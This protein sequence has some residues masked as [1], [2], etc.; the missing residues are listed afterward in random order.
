MVGESVFSLGCQINFGKVLVYFCSMKWTTL[1]FLIGILPLL[2]V[3]AQ[4]IRDY[5]GGYT[6]N[7][8]R[9]TGKFSYYLTPENE[10]V[11]QGPFRFELKLLDSLG[12]ERLTKLHVEGVYEKY[13]KDKSWSYQLEDHVVR[14][15]DVENRDV[16]AQIETKRIDLLAQYAKGKLHGTWSYSEKNWMNEQFLETFRTNELIFSNDRLTGKVRFENLNP[17]N[18]FLIAGTLTSEGLMDGAWDF[19]YQES[20]IPIREIRRYEKG[21]LIGLQ[22]NNEV[23]GE[24]LDEVVFFNAIQK[25][26]S[27]D[28]GFEVDYTLSDRFFGLTFNDGFGQQ[29]KEFRQQYQ[30]TQ[31]LEDALVRLLRFEDE[32][33]VKADRLLKSP[34]QTRRFRYDLSKNEEEAYQAAVVRYQELKSAVDLVLSSSFLELNRQS[35]DS[36]TLAGAYFERLNQKLQD[37]IPVVEVIK[38]G[39]I[40]YFDPLFYQKNDLDFLPASDTLFLDAKSVGDARV[41]TFPDLKIAKSFGT[42]LLKYLEKELENFRI[43]DRFLTDQQQKFRQNL[44]L[45]SIEKVILSQKKKLDSAYRNMRFDSNAQ[46]LLLSQ[47]MANL[48]ESDYQRRLSAFNDETSFEGKASKGD[49]LIDLLRFLNGN[50]EKMK[51]VTE[52]ENELTELFTETTF[53]PF[54][55]ETEFEVIRQ[56]NLYQAGLDLINFERNQLLEATDYQEAERN[57]INLENLMIRLNKLRK[58]DTRK[59]E[60]ELLRAGGD[61]NQLKKLLS[62]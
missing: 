12:K 31:L 49:E 7:G 16:I 39:E 41:F 21:F 46:R 61:I 24:K 55:F 19:S 9:G 59:L 18:P 60:R 33:F 1:A 40:A 57:L 35:N 44:D 20:G 10:P 17:S 42:G 8:Q 45:V 47:V 23:T 50:L 37:L 52:L 38:S 62:L 11:L 3:K 2:Q 14:I 27:L 58:S 43:F 13:Q 56:K 28:R 22:K 4:E 32:E 15:Q 5:Q 36:L 29:S 30:G 53:D 26:D 51:S 34:I 25:L 48:A 6:F 54:T